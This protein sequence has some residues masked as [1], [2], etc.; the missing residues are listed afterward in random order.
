MKFKQTPRDLQDKEFDTF[1]SVAIPI[2]KSL[3]MDL[4]QRFI[5]YN[6]I[7]IA[8]AS[9]SDCI[10]ITN[11]S[12]KDFI[13]RGNHGTIVRK[14]EQLTIKNNGLK[15]SENSIIKIYADEKVIEELDIEPME[16]GT[17]RIVRLQNLL[18]TKISINELKLVIEYAPN[19]LDKSNNEIILQIKN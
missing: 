15:K 4:D 7:H 12:R 19:E 9:G 5:P 17:G 16:I 18:V 11:W 14:T 2:N 13:P 10:A 1:N 6:I 3:D 8:N